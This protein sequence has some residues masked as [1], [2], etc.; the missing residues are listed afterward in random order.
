MPASWWAAARIRI[1]LGRAGAV[2]A[3]VS[4]L[5]VGVFLV[6]SGPGGHGAAG[7]QQ[8]QQPSQCRRVLLRRLPARHV[9]SGR[10]R[11]AA[12]ANLCRFYQ[13]LSPGGVGPCVQGFAISWHS[14]Q[15][16]G[17]SCS[18][19]MPAYACVPIRQSVKVLC[20]LPGQCPVC[21]ALSRQVATA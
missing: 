20:I 13:P 16:S 2:A 1:E 12:G 19:C 11:Q 10:S 17:N 8:Q 14:V 9:A 5:V 6:L 18:S 21:S 15:H 3:L 7:Q 4:G